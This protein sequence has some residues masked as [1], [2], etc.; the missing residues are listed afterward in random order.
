MMR[1]AVVSVRALR[2]VSA[3]AL[4]RPSAIASAK[5]ANSTVSHSQ[6]VIC[7]SK[8][9]PGRR[10]DGVE[11][12]PD[13]RQDAADLD[14][15]HDRVL[16]HRPRVQLAERVDDRAADDGRIPDRLGFRVCLSGHQ[17]T[18]PLR[19]QQVL[20]D[21]AEAEGREERQRADDDDDAD[22]Q[23]REQRRRHRE[24]AGR[25]RHALLAAEA[26]GDRQHR[27]DHEEAADQRRERRCV[28]L[29]Q[30]VLAVRPA[31]AEPLLPVPD[32]KA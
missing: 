21:R 20:D 7:S 25:R 14:D 2:S 23:R 9:R 22:E 16:R 26:A 6:N 3:C 30:C 12:E 10:A 11:R 19:H 27:D 29:Y 18:W 28:T 24:R 17:N 4:P 32:V 5:L 8:P 31:N 15:E 13:R 1:F